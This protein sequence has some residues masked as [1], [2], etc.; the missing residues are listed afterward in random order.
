MRHLTVTTKEAKQ[1]ALLLTK[2]RLD[3][4]Y[5]DYHDIAELVQQISLKAIEAEDYHKNFSTWLREQVQ[6]ANGAQDDN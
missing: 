2:V 3:S 4:Q 5:S 1:L 6:K